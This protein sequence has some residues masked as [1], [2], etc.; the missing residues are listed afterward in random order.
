MGTK[1]QHRSRF[2]VSLAVHLN[3]FLRRDSQCWHL[4]SKQASHLLNTILNTQQSLSWNIDSLSSIIIFHLLKK[5]KVDLSTFFFFNSL[6]AKLNPVCHLL[7]LLGA[8]RILH[9]SRIRVKPF[10]WIMVSGLI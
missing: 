7:A 2:C 4:A 10:P 9:V 1:G 8:Y 3:L 6:N 5:K